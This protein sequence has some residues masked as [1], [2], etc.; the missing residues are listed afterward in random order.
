MKRTAWSDLRAVLKE[1]ADI[2]HRPET[3]DAQAMHERAQQLARPLAAPTTATPDTLRTLVFTLG[4]ERYSWPVYSVK[5]IAEIERLTPVPST[6]AYYAGVTNFRG[7]I[8]S[9]MDLRIYMNLAPLRE[10]PHYM[11]I[12]DGANLEI[13][14]LATDVFDVLSVK[15][16]SL[17]PAAGLDVE[18]ITGVMPDGLTVLDAES[19]LRRE[20]FRAESGA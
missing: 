6:P 9:V 8:L 7:R 5:A 11:I 3:A 4:T 18:L 1:T 19:L 17:V 15:R 12:I 13:G 14:V 16:S 20:R 10:Q 2:L